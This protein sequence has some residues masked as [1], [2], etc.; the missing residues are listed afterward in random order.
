I[1][2][3]ALPA[4]HSSPI[5]RLLRAFPSLRTLTIECIDPRLAEE[6]GT[7]HLATPSISIAPSR[8]L[9]ILAHDAILANAPESAIVLY[10][11]GS[12][13]DGRAGAAVA[14]RRRAA[15]GEEGEGDWRFSAKGAAMGQHQPVYAAE[16]AGIHL[17]LTT[18]KA[19]LALQQKDEP[20]EAHIFLDNQSAVVNSCSASPSSGQ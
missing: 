10:T 15:E 19:L 3:S 12:L 2:I 13:L 7:T 4:T 17:A 8:D 5:P 16:L 1:R 20:L 14:L 6:P 18:L 11:D 9:A